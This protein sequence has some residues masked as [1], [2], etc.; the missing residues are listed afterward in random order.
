MQYFRLIFIFSLVFTLS[1]CGPLAAVGIVG[2]TISRAMENENTETAP[3]RTNVNNAQRREEIALANLNLGVAYMQQGQ[4]ENALEKMNRAKAA[5][6]DYPPTYNAL[7]LLYQK[8]G[9][10]E[11]AEE[12]FKHAIRLSPSDSSSLNNYGLFLCQNQ[13]FEEAEDTFMLAA[14]NP[15]Y[16]TPEIAIT[17]A[18]TCALNNNQID[19]AERYFRE[20]LN[21]NP[22]IAPALLKMSELT[23]KQNDY[24]NARAYLQRYLE[25]GKHTPKSLWLGIEIER[26]LGDKNAVSSY[27]LLLRNKYPD[28]EEAKLLRESGER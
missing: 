10:Q 13:R 22:E 7:G 25:I 3:R 18:G 9:E 21:R 27:A 20:A 14:S 15:L 19:A 17:N 8:L 2:S 6:S 24:L 26:E 4:Y 28:T 23:Y 5:K 1:A 16:A 11:A 12:N